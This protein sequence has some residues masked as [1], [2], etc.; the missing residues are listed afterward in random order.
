MSETQLNDLLQRV[1][2]L[3][4]SFSS[5]KSPA[6]DERGI[7]IR[8]KIPNCIRPAVKGFDVE[9]KDGMG[10][11]ARVPLV[12]I[13]DVERSPSARIGYYLVYLFAADGSS[14]NL[15]LNQGTTELIGNKLET[16][17]TE[18]L[19]Q[20]REV[21]RQLLSDGLHDL[22]PKISLADKRGLGDG[23]E[24]GHIAGWSYERNLI[25]DESVL[26]EH[27]VRG[28]QLLERL[29]GSTS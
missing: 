9:G 23:Y 26:V 17:P 2:E 18:I 10:R 7:L 14:V 11:K 1:L 20:R 27:L 21:G 3:Q 19:G 22:V 4:S 12:R 6:M 24:A 8:N 28:S 16:I 5:L 13:F 15:S 29:Y 25:P